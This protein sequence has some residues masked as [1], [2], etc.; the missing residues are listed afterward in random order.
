MINVID[1][2]SKKG[3]RTLMFGYKLIEGQIYDK[4]KE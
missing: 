1:N 3:Y 4:F 2:L